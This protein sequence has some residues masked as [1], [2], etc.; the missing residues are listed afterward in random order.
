MQPNRPLRLLL[1]NYILTSTYCGVNAC[2]A[3][4]LDS[5]LNMKAVV[6]TFSVIVQRRR[7]LLT[8]LVWLCVGCKLFCRISQ[9]LVLVVLA[10]QLNV[11]SFQCVVV[12]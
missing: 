8:A 6:A 12:S 7:L 4:C 5:V 10:A 1:H 11:E 9:L 3:Y 2:L